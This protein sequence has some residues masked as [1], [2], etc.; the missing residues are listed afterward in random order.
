MWNVM[1][2]REVEKEPFGATTPGIKQN[3]EK[4]RKRRAED[5]GEERRGLGGSETGLIRASP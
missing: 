5:K 3:R 2:R 4:R 1:G